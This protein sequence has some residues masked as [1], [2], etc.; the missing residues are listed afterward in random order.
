MAVLPGWL[1]PAA[2]LL[3][4]LLLHKLAAKIRR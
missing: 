2:A 1:V 3:F 4:L